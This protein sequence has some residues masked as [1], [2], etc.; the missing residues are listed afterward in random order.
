MRDKL[1]ALILCAE[2]YHLSPNENHNWME[3]DAAILLPHLPQHPIHIS[4]FEN[5]ENSAYLREQLLATNAE[6]EY[7]F[8]DAEV[9]MNPSQQPSQSDMEQ[10]NVD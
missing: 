5:V 7:A 8:V 2:S 6:Y 3:Q 9:V 10:F 1:G 4:L